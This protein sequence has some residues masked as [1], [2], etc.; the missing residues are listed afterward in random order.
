[1]TGTGDQP[2]HQALAPFN[3]DRYRGH[4]AER[5]ELGEDGRKLCF[6]VPDHPSLEDCAVVSN[7]THP[8]LS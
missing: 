6:G 7:Q 4:I 8:V 2:N 3:R 5:A 1:M